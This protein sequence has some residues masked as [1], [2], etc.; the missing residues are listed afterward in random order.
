MVRQ[1]QELFFERRYSFTEITSPDFVKVAEG[2]GIA[3]TSVSE[4]RTLAREIKK[5]LD[6]KGA[7][8]LEIKVEQEDNVFP[9][10]P[11]GASVTEI[12][13]K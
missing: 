10:V 7:Y 6:H 5:M 4:K 9:M 11:S 1:W 13:F 12:R 8:L 3:G 2:F